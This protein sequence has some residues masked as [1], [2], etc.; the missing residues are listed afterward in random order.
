MI[1]QKLVHEHGIKPTNIILAGQK[2]MAMSVNT[3]KFIDSLNHIAQGLSTFP[4]TFGLNENQFKKGFFPYLFNLKENQ[5]YVGPIPDESYFEPDS[6][7]SNKRAEFKKWYPLQ[8][9]TYDFQKELEEYCDS[10][11]RILQK[12]LEVYR[13]TGIAETGIDPLSC[14]T[15]AGYAM[16]VYRTNHMPENKIAVLLKKEYDHSK[17]GMHGGRTQNLRLHYKSDDPNKYLVYVDICSLYPT[18]QF[19]DYL[20]CGIPK[21]IHPEILETEDLSTQELQLA[22]TNRVFGYYDVDVTCP[23]DLL[24]PVLPEV[25]DGKL[26]F[27]LIDKKNEVYTNIELHKAI[28]LGYKITKIHSVLEFKKDR[29]MF[30]TY[31]RQNLKNKT[32]AGFDGTL[33]ERN[34]KIHAYKKFL[35]IDLDP[36]RM[37][38]NPGRKL[39]AKILLNSLWGKFGQKFAMPSR[40]YITDTSEWYKL[41]ARQ[42]KG[43]IDIASVESMSDEM[44]FVSY[45]ELDEG[46]TTLTSTN[47]ALAGFVTSNARLRLYEMMEK[48]GSRVYYCDTDSL[49]Y[50]HD[51]SEGAFNVPEGDLLGSWE[52]E[53]PMSKIDWTGISEEEREFALKTYKSNPIIE[54]ISTAPK[55]YAYRVKY[56]IKKKGSVFCKFKG[57][58]LNHQNKEFINLE[59]MKNLVFGSQ[60]SIECYTMN[61][62]K[63]NKTGIITTTKQCKATSFAVSKA[64]LIPGTTDTVPFG[65]KGENP[66]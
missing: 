54:Y 41:I 62:H 33:E 47:V 32:E 20:P 2:V 36:S 55:E 37:E 49:I 35:D 46:K 1:H 48:L 28:S 50:E 56:P 39:L 31:V 57:F 65:Y 26:I 7:S 3:V 61:F 16:K 9:G 12:S 38:D 66:F 30:K 51:P 27:D 40:I 24:I 5:N 60:K 29:D 45:H 10:D 11:V 19:N 4:V 18:V 14:T 17:R 58:T 22:Y 64:E 6:M 34:E 59:T 15:V 13:D 25:K 44:I 43:E 21:W 52:N 63:N 8:K 42:E 23:K 53:C